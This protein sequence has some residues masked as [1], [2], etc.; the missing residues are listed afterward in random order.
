MERLVMLPELLTIVP[1]TS[2]HIRR[3]EKAGTFPKRIH[4]GP[5]RVV[6]SYQEVSDWFD[7]R[8]LKRSVPKKTPR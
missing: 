8:K 5:G 4:L 7:Q 2:M 6:W 3:M 1:F